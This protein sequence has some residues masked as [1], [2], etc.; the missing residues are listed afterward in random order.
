MA[1]LAAEL[2]KLRVENALLKKRV[3]LLTANGNLSQNPTAISSS[4]YAGDAAAS[5]FPEEVQWIAGARHSLSGLEIRRYSRQLLLPS[6]GVEAQQ[7]LAKASVLVVGA[8]GLGS[9][10]L[11]YL[12]ASGV[13][14]LGIMDP[15][16][17]ELHNLHRQV[18]HSEASVGELKVKSA[19][20]TC[21]AINSSLQV[22]E[23][24]F[25]LEAANALEVISDYD[26]VVDASDNVA[27]RYLISDACVVANK[28]LVSGAALGMDGQLTVYNHAQGPCRRCLCP[29]PPSQSACQRCADAGVLGVVP[30]IVGTLQALEVIK[31][32][33]GVGEPFSERMLVFDALSTKIR[34]VNLRGRNPQCAA[35][36]DNPQV[37]RNTLPEFDYEAFTSSPL[38]DAPP[39]RQ[40]IVGEDQSI[41]CRGY[42]EVREAHEAHLL[43]DVREQHEYAIAALPSS[44]NIPF[45]LLSQQWDAIVAAAEV[46]T[47]LGVKSLPV[48]VICRRGNDS[49]AAVNELRSFGLSAYDITGGFQSWVQDV[50]PNFPFF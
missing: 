40:Q 44:L 45:S 42:K 32:L 28:P 18:I 22:R 47:S 25:A 17:V 24:A 38:C 9:P 4:G 11:L 26:I 30:G 3:S 29:T 16:S 14:C 49:Q 1:D 19:A 7:K 23:Y 8:G 46:T 35:C 33:T 43:L 31:I 41:T 37:D 27:T 6:F 13:G 5:A 10:V 34:T 2:H 50:D 36:G 39:P 21:L 15:D 20:A 48:Y 12:A